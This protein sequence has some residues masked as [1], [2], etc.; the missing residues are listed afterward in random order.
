MP[1][2]VPG[3][4]INHATNSEPNLMIQVISWYRFSVEEI[5]TH[6][7]QKLVE[8]FKTNVKIS[9]KTLCP[10]ILDQA[11]CP[12]SYPEVETLPW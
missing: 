11:L 5:D 6:K 2:T 3:V 1:D 10:I 7:V 8:F 9:T 4:Y 12:L